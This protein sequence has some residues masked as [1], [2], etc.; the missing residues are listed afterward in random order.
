MRSWW[1]TLPVLDRGWVDPA[2]WLLV[3]MAGRRGCGVFVRRG[4]GRACAVLL[5]GASVRA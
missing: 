1:D 2:G 3:V 4:R 5:R